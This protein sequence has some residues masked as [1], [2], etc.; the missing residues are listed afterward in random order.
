MPTG[1][2]KSAVYQIASLL[3]P[4]PTVIVSPLLALQQDQSE[5][6]E[7]HDA[8]EVAVVN[9]LEGEVDRRAALDG[10]QQE[11]VQFLFLAPEQ[12]HNEEV[13]SRLR[14]ANPSLFVVDEAHCVSEWGHDFR[15]EYLRLGSVVDVLGHPP[16]L[17]L[18]ATASPPV[19]QEIVERLSMRES[20]VVVRDFN[21]PNIW[22]GVEKFQ[23]EKTKTRALLERVE[24]ADKPGI[25][26]VSTKKHAE[27]V[28]AALCERGM[29][30]IAYHAGLRARVRE[31]AQEDFMT[32]EMDVMVATIAFGMG[33]DKPNVRFV[34]HFDVSDSLD[35]YYQEIGRGGRDGKP[36][37]AILFYRSADLGIHR[38]FAGGG[39]VDATQIKKVATAIYRHDEPIEPM[40]L[41]KETRLSRSK[42]SS[43]LSRLEEAGTIEILPTGQVIEAD[44]YG[45]LGTA[46]EEAAEAEER[47]RAYQSSRIDMMR[48][49]AEVWGCRRE[50]L[51][52]YFGEPFDP[53]CGYCD[54]CDAGITVT[55]G[56]ADLLFPLNSRVVH[57]SLGPGL[58]E[59]YDG[60]TMVVLFDEAGYRTLDVGFVRETGALTPET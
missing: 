16:V 57:G 52:N 19:R 9:S 42:L 51:L 10:L 7:Q 12:F 56:E 58:V 49:Y 46:A 2:G 14:E 32:D 41:A 34:F 18:T 3:L 55:D 36:A 17:A 11:A 29:K 50:Y 53:P 30:A 21:R 47:H 59:R 26:Y 6:I 23:D 4:G 5:A 13:L 22:L 54:N 39:R 38:F 35:P 43:A 45:Q 60:D 37:K 20:T 27:E 33:V 48:G 1:S 8:G 31:Q 40:E 28:A 44:G 25:V 15:P 24:A